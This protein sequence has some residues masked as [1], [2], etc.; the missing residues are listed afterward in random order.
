[1]AMPP[2]DLEARQR[3]QGFAPHQEVVIVP[4]YRYSFPALT[5]LT[6]CTMEQLIEESFQ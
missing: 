4:P 6:V 3:A 1:M 5:S 2:A